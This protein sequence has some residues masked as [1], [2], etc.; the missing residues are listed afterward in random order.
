MIIAAEASSQL[1]SSSELSSSP[2]DGKSVS[3]HAPLNDS[4]IPSES[5]HFLADILSVNVNTTVIKE[6]VKITVS[7]HAEIIGHQQ[8][9]M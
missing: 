4:N 1:I 2:T 7:V 6:T 3:V 9:Q 5:S 8:C